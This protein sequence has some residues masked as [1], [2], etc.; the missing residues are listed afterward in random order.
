[1]KVLRNGTR[2]QNAK[3]TK[4]KVQKIHDKKFSFC[5]LLL[6]EILNYTM[7]DDA[8]ASNGISLCDEELRK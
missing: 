6:K 8:T 4:E 3:N 7:S 1:M 5:W 2:W